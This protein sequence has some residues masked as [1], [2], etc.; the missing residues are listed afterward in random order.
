MT[1]DQKSARA[2]AQRLRREA[3][4]SGTTAVGKI[5]DKK[6]AP[7]LL[8]KNA[9]AR[10]IGDAPRP[11]FS[12]GTA[13]SEAIRRDLKSLARV[14]IWAEFQPGR[15]VG[16]KARKIIQSLE[17][18]DFPSLSN[19]LRA[20]R[21]LRCRQG[22]RDSRV[23]RRCADERIE[24]GRYRLDRVTTVKE[25]GRVG[26]LLDLCVATGREFARSYERKLRDGS[27][28]FWTMHDQHG[29]PV[30]LLEIDADDR[31]ISQA[32][33]AAN[34]PLPADCAE[35]LRDF[36]KKRSLGASEISDLAHLWLNGPFLYGAGK[37]IGRGTVRSQPYE[38][39]I[40]KGWL[41]A[42]LESAASDGPRTVIY[43]DAQAI[44]A[45]IDDLDYADYVDPKLV[46]VVL[47][48]AIDGHDLGPLGLALAA[49]KD[50]VS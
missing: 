12:V 27:S 47:K 48:A 35:S 40:R 11:R 4:I 21:S 30:A 3:K 25:L 18:G 33:A 45:S 20:W 28:E 36:A 6:L 38:L 9:A 15:P 5:I 24:G 46:A 14:I 13:L 32:K 22:R 2:A 49:H 50:A 41:A 31:T 26:R 43:G 17:K 8:A 42:S 19:A 23:T 16:A 34:A 37:L 39:R 29:A 44:G 1:S 10:Q 7:Y